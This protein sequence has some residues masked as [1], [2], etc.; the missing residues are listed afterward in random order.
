MSAGYSASHR[1]GPPAPPAARANQHPAVPGL[2]LPDMRGGRIGSAGQLAWMLLG[3]T[4]IEDLL[5]QVFKGW[6]FLVGMH[7]RDGMPTASRA[8]PTKPGSAG[9]HVPQTCSLQGRRR[10]YAA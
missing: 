7:A 3:S 1:P 4:I 9:A 10:R 8:A 2:R 6:P 5:Q